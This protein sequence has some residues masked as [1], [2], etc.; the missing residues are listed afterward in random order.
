MPTATFKR[1]RRLAPGPVFW[2]VALPMAAAV[3]LM[4]GWAGYLVYLSFEM[5]SDLTGLHPAFCGVLSVLCLC[6]FSINSTRWALLPAVIQT[7]LGRTLVWVTVGYQFV[8]NQWPAEHVALLALPLV[9]LSA[10][11]AFRWLRNR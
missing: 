8:V 9:L 7:G 2:S 6:S 5:L 10:R 1:T 11:M 3:L 4:A